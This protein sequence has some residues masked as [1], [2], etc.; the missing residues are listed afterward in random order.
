MWYYNGFKNFG[1]RLSTYIL[2][3]YGKKY[4]IKFIYTPDKAKAK[5]IGIGSILHSMPANFRGQVWSSGSLQNAHKC[6][7]IG[8][9]WGVRGKLTSGGKLPVIGDGA[10]LLKYLHPNPVTKVYKL[11]IIPHYVDRASI[12]KMFRNRPDVTILNVQDDPAIFI[13]KLRQCRCIFSSSLHG[14]IAADAFKI[15]NRQ[16][17]ISTSRQIRGGLFKYK[18]YYSAFGIALPKC[19]N[20]TSDISTTKKWYH[21][22]MKYYSRPGITKLQ[23]NLRTITQEMLLGFA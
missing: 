2:N 7:H 19:I 20:L 10:L 17:R 15:P 4:N 6:H 3:H 9:V 5:L 1:D 21:I 23:E 22:T 18:D 12:Q 8:K 16:F 14:L 13:K 11:G